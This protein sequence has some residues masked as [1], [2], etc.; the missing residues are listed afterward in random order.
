MNNNVYLIVIMK[1][2]H[3][4]R[5]TDSFIIFFFVDE[6]S[7][8]WRGTVQVKNVRLIQSSDSWSSLFFFNQTL[9]TQS[10]QMHF[11]LSV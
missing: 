6:K 10:N 11:S 8:S 5:H 4:D 3:K 7:E 9:N 1:L 2:S